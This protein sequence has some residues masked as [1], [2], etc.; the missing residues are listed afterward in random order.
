GGSQ[1]APQEGPPRAGPAD[2]EGPVGGARGGPRHLGGPSADDRAHRAQTRRRLEDLRYFVNSELGISATVWGF[3]AF[4]Q[5][6][7]GAAK[8]AAPDWAL[9][10]AALAEHVF[11]AA[12]VEVAR[13]ANVQAR[14]TALLVAGSDG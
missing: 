11:G 4:E 9:V 13:A 1:A 6:E 7:K 5:I 8:Y 14:E 10:G 3:P 2:A 12:F